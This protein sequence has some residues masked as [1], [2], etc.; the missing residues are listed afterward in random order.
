LKTLSVLAPLAGNASPC[1][2]RAVP[3]TLLP[4]PLP[5]ACLPVS[6]SLQA[7]FLEL[8]KQRPTIKLLYV[9]PEQLVKGQRLK[10]ALG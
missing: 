8:G 6:F 1:C 4:L 5:M 10:E 9:T 7:V 2:C 3:H